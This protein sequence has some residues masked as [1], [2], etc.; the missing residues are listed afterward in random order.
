VHVGRNKVRSVDHINLQYAKEATD[1]IIDY[2]HDISGQ[3]LSKLTSDLHLISEPN[4]YFSPML[5]SCSSESHIEKYE[6]CKKMKNKYDDIR[7]D[8]KM[9]FTLVY[10]YNDQLDKETHQYNYV[11]LKGFYKGLNTQ[12][13]DLKKNGF[14]V[15]EEITYKKYRLKGHTFKNRKK[16]PV[17]ITIIPSLVLC[18][19]DLGTET[20]L[21][22]SEICMGQK[23]QSKYA[24]EQFSKSIENDDLNI[25]SMYSRYGNGPDFGPFF[26]TQGKFSIK[27][28]VLNTVK[29]KSEKFLFLSSCSSPKHFTK[30]IDKYNRENDSCNINPFSNNDISFFGSSIWNQS[31]NNI[32][33]A[34]MDYSFDE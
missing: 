25:Y 5:P 10:G 23:S 18:S 22:S 12:V 14:T 19:N 27:A 11:D 21:N 17:Y 3:S 20:R 16:I 34:L 8:N 32:F 29:P 30:S 9:S 26:E 31:L 33:Y 13:D 2:G 24:K 28:V 7:K 1:F 15:V 6:P 4:Y